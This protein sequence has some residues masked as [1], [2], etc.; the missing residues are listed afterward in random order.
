LVPDLLPCRTWYGLQK[1]VLNCLRSKWL[2]ARKTYPYTDSSSFFGDKGALRPGEHPGRLHI[3]RW[4]N[5]TPFYRDGLEIVA[6]KA[7]HFWWGQQVTMGF[8]SWGTFLAIEGQRRKIPNLWVF[9]ALGQLV[10]LSY[11]Q[12]LFF[13]A[14]LLT[15]VPLPENVKDLTRTSLPATSGR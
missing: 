10:N 4:L 1:G 11:A 9:M 12:N 8:V 7:R 15:P 6:E 14:L 13:V 5:D 3:V 2:I